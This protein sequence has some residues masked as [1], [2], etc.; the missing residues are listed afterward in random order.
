MNPL[1]IVPPWP[2]GEA[3]PTP[4][5]PVP[6]ARLRAHVGQVIT[7]Q[8]RLTAASDVASAT[9]HLKLSLADATGTVLAFVWPEYRDQAQ[10]PPL[11]RPVQVQATVRVHEERSQ[12]RIHR[13]AALDADVVAFAADLVCTPEQAR[14][15]GLLRA[16][17]QSLPQPLRGLLARVLL[18]PAIGIPLLACRASGQHHHAEPGGLGVHC[19]ENLD[20]IGAT[21]RRTLPDDPDSV[22][23][24]RIGYFLHDLGKIRTVGATVRPVLHHVVRHEIHTLLLLAPHLAWLQ[25]QSSELHAALVHVLEYV[26]MPA[27]SRTR[28]RYFPAEVVVQFDQWS[29]AAHARRDLSALCR[30]SGT[31][32]AEAG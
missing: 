22:A 7:G 32:R 17:E 9:P 19:L 26:A 12:L 1:R 18:D 29:A 14:V 5:T 25:N 21:V 30:T 3:S 2:A 6:V 15:H 28:A 31:R 24:A 13:L 11:G 27:A 4:S 20:L 10:L 23:I 8:Y 16:L